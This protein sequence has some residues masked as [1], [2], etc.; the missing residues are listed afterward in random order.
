ML[1]VV[2]IAK[3]FHL[4]INLLGSCV[5]TYIGTVLPVIMYQKHF[6]Q[7][8][9]EKKRYLNYAIMILGTILGVLGVVVSV[10]EIINYGQD[11]VSNIIS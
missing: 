11:E 9:P 6:S 1:F 4:F 8:L 3:S 10:Q 2:F 5:F 7:K